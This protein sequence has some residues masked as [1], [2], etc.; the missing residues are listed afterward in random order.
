MVSSVETIEKAKSIMAK[1]DT[2]V[3]EVPEDVCDREG[4]GKG[5]LVSLTIKDGAITSTFIPRSPEAKAAAQRFI[6]KYGDFMKE[7]APF[8]Q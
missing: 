2:W 3:F 5:T 6:A 7:I 8:D 1:K 4:L